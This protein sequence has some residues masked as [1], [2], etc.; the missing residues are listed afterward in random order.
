MLKVRVR[1]TQSSGLGTDSI[2][3]RFET[4][5]ISIQYFELWYKNTRI[6]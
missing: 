6:M 4:K 2:I 5:E 3:D 1:L